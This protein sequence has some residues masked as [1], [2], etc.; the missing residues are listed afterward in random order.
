MKNKVILISIDGMRPDGVLSCGNPFVEEM[1]RIGSYTL[2]AQTVYPSVTLPSH[3]S[4]FH[5]V[6]PER[7]GITVNQY[8]PQVRPIKGLFEQIAANGGSSIM[9][10]GWETL[11]DVSRPDS[12]RY[13]LSRK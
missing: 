2:D 12:L 13:V 5:S 4:M 7:H 8:M 6:T 3:M 11:R 9:Y 10:Y 1:K